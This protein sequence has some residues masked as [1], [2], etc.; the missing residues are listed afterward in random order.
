MKYKKQYEILHGQ[1][2]FPGRSMLQ[3]VPQIADLVA[4]FKSKKHLDYGCGEGRQWSHERAQNVIG[5]DIPTLYD[6]FTSAWNARPKD[7]FDGVICTD[8]MEHVP[9]DELKGVV[10]EIASF[11]TQWAF[12][13]VCCRPSK[14]M[15]FEDGTNIHVTIHP[16]A[17]W[18]EFLQ[19][20]FIDTRLVLVESP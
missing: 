4:E 7:K 16:F 5:I 6:P 10:E 20:H 11:A 3:Y 1:G 8:V 9:E 12:I 19:P 2:K 18:K 17:W 13:S 14:H 15:R